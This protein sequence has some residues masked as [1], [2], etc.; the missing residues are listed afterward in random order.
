ML[1]K[2]KE[3]IE[4]A[5][6][7]WPAKA[8]ALLAA[9][10]L[11]VFNRMNTLEENVFRVPLKVLLPTSYAIASPY[12][13][14]IN[15]TVKWGKQSNVPK[16]AQESIVN[17]ISAFVDFSDV[18]TIGIFKRSV[19]Y[20]ESDLTKGQTFYIEHID[21]PQIT[22]TLEKEV[23]KRVNI[24]ANLVGEPSDGYALYNSTLNPSTIILRGP[25]SLVEPI[26][27]IRTEVIN[28][29]GRTQ[30]I[31]TIIQL[32]PFNPLVSLEGINS[33]EFNG[34]IKERSVI[35]GIN[36]A[37]IVLLNL[38]PH[39]EPETALS[40]GYLKLQGAEMYINHADSLQFKLQVDLTSIIWPGKYTLPVK[41]L[42]P[43]EVS[44]IEYYPNKIMINLVRKN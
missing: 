29:A 34:E 20:K 21:P 8:L 30:N 2:P 25:E 31:Q 17:Y 9:I 6:S 22:I 35:K 37:P 38:S 40:T 42:V 44:V 36:D 18:K 32:L 33:I 15:I 11:F 26:Q 28:L 12:P 13:S 19:Q 7:Y 41:P 27:T 23:V 1:L 24:E 39:L 16:V 10:M 5:F 3:I 14:E 43:K 4:Y